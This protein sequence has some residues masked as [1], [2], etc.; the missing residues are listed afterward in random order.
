MSSRPRLTVPK[1]FYPVGVVRV[2]PEQR[3]RLAIVERLQQCE[4]RLADR[5]LIR[6]C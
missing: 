4:Q 1:A 6:G 3:F 2:H 5:F